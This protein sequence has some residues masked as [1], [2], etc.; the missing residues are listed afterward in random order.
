MDHPKTSERLRSLR[1]PRGDAS[2][3][4]SVGDWTLL[5]EGLDAE[6]ARQLD[7]RWGAFLSREP[8]SGPTRTV[9]VFDAGE[10]GWL[11]LTRLGEPYRMEALGP[12]GD[13]VV[14]SYHFGMASQSKPRGWRVGISESADEPTQRMLDNVMRYVVARLALD[15]GG[16]AL[17]AATMLHQGRAFLFAGPSGAGKTTAM[18]LSAPAVRLGDDFAL[19]VPDAGRWYAPALPF[20]NAER[21]VGQPPAGLLPAAGI[22][23]LYQSERP[24]VETPAPG[25]AAASLMGCAAFPWAVP[26][27]AGALLDHVR[28]FLAEAHFAHLHFD[29]TAPLVEML[30]R[31]LGRLGD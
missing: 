8:V 18:K 19:V 29:K 20:D 14:V 23:R 30:L 28:A 25:L 16:F 31:D 3:V 11:E 13:D 15:H 2:R 22:W 7:R 6:L 21:V 12:P 9:H 5:I 26:K 27:Q 24:R 10:A 17:H 4:L 1:H